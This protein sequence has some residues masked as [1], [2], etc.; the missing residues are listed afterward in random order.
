MNQLGR[1]SGLLLLGEQGGWRFPCC[2]PSETAA[3]AS[4]CLL[5]SPTPLPSAGASLPTAC[6]SIVFATWCLGR[7][8]LAVNQTRPV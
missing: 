7:L 5:S 6:F 1:W 2:Q 4:E 8:C 3:D